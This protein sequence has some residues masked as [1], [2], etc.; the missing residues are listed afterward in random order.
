MKKIKKIASLAMAFGLLFSCFG[1]KEDGGETESSSSSGEV[2]TTSKTAPVLLY[3]FEDWKPSFHLIRTD[4]YAS[5]TR[6]DEYAKTGKYSAKLIPGGGPSG[7]N[8]TFSLPL[9]STVFDFAHNILD[10]RSIS[11]GFYNPQE[12]DVEV[13]LTLGNITKNFDLAPGWNDVEYMIEHNFLNIFVDYFEDVDTLKVAFKNNPECMYGDLSKSVV[14]YLDDIT[15][16]PVLEPVE[17]VDISTT[18]KYEILDF[19]ELYQEY[20]MESYAWETATKPTYR[21]LDYRKG[22]LPAGVYPTHG[23]RVLEITQQPGDLKFNNDG[24]P[25]VI[26][27]QYV[28][29]NACSLLTEEELENAYICFDVYNVDFS[30]FF[31]IFFGDIPQWGFEVKKGQWRTKK[32]RLADCINLE[33]DKLSNGCK[34]RLVT[35]ERMQKEVVYLDNVRLEVIK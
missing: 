23:N 32:M 34:I 33:T 11:F 2:V 27:P 31:D 15:L 28:V 4:S 16:N 8:P 3:D 6:S 10:Y 24:Y 30:Y 29:K 5:I 19:E 22:E 7:A 12:E 14:V 1:C 21:A 18:R 35:A 26:I 9:N 17:L 25:E 20:V 13:M